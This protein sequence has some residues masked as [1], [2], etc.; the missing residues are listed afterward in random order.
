MAEKKMPRKYVPN[1]APRSVVNSAEKK[2]I[3]KVVNGSASVKKKG[4]LRKLANMVITEDMSTVKSQ[5]FGDVLVPTIK[6]LISDFITVGI[7]RLLF[8]DSR[9]GITNVGRSVL[10]RV[11]YTPYDRFS[12][13]RDRYTRSDTRVKGGYSYLDNDIIVP[14]RGDA[15]R[16]LREMDD[17]L[18]KYGIVSV[19]DFNEMVGIVGPYTDAKFGWTKLN[20][21]E[22]VR[23]SDGRY[24]I[25]LPKAMPIDQ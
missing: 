10:D 17:L 20:T 7:N 24:M 2:Q 12:D 22:A 6:N 21:A 1:D 11:T 8:G 18:D 5:L 25:K 19:A 16:V 4:E 13:P 23:T 15:E 9:P 14:T 3:K